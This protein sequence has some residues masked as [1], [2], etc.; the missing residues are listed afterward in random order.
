[1]VPSLALKKMTPLSKVKGGVQLVSSFQAMTCLGPALSSTEVLGR[2]FFPV[3][4]NGTP[5]RW[6]RAHTLGELLNN[7]VD[8]PAVYTTV[9]ASW[10][11]LLGLWSFLQKVVLE[12]QR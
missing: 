3:L 8:G 12:M 2:E 4:P 1:M 11:S 5:Q 7:R 10:Q 6:L 9:Q